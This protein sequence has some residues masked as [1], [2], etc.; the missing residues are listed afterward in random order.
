MTS[1]SVFG[2]DQQKKR[3]KVKKRR[4]D[5]GTKERVMDI[6]GDRA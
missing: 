1:L 3:A 4:T 6:A 2:T 5:R